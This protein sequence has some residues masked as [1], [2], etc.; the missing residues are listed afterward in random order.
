LLRT[1]QA[2]NT[3]A[4]CLKPPAAGPPLCPTLQ[5]GQYCP[6]SQPPRSAYREAS[7]GHGILNFLSPTEATFEWHRC[8][9]SAAAMHARCQ[10]AA[11]CS[12]RSPAILNRNQDGID[13]VTDSFTFVR[14]TTCPNQAKFVAAA[15]AAADPVSDFANSVK[16]G[17]LG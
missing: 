8:A 10:I 1:C 12:R 3:T 13:V 16:T 7:F 2:Y 11:A 17:L 15:A 6:L 4:T 14:N 5:N 9:V